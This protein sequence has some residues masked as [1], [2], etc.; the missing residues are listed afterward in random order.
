VHKAETRFAKRDGYGMLFTN[1]TGTGKTFSGLGIVK[2]QERQNKLDQLIIVPDEK[3][4]D[5]WMDSGKPLDLAITR[6]K[7]TKDAGEGIVITTLANLGQND[8][9]ARRKWSHVAVDEAHGLMQS[10]DGDKTLYLQRLHA[11]TGHPDGVRT[12]VDM[13]HREL[14]NELADVRQ[15]ADDAS[16]DLNAVSDDRDRPRLTAALDKLTAQRAKLE[17]RY[18]AALAEVQAEVD[19]MQGEDRTRVTFLSA[20]PFAYEKTVDWANGYLFDYQ[21]DYPYKDVHAYNTPSPHGHFFIRHFGYRMRYGKLTEPDSKVDRGLMQRQF[22]GWLRKQGVL[23]SRMLDVE[24][25]YDR[26]FIAVSNAIGNRIDEALEWLSDSSYGDA[27]IEG[28]SG[29]RD[30]DR[31][32]VR[33]PHAP[34]PAGGDQGQGGRA[35]RQGAPGA[36]PQGRRLPRL[37][38]GRRRQPVQLR[39]RGRGHP[40][41]PGGQAHR[42]GEAAARRPRAGLQLRRA[43]FRAKFADLVGADF[44]RLASPINEFRRSFGADQL[45]MINGLEK[46]TDVLQAY[47][48]FQDDGSG[49]LVALVQADKNKGWSGHD[50]TGK[51]QRVLI[52]LGLPTQPTRSI[53]QEGRIYRTGQHPDSHAIFRYL[54]TGTNWEKWA[55]ATTIAT[56]ASAAEN[57]SMGEQA[58]ALKDSYIAAFDEADTFPPGPRGRGPRRQGA[59]QAQANA[60]L[61]EWDRAKAFYW[62]TQ[63][64]TS[65]TKAQ[66]GKDYFAT[67]EPVGLKMVQWAG[68]R[69][70]DDALEPSAGH[71]AIARWFHEQSNRTAIEPSARLR[72]SLAMVFDGK[73]VEGTFEDHNVVNKYDAIVMNPPFGQGGKTAVDHLAKAATHLREDGRIVALIPTGPAADKKLEKFLY[74]KETRPAKPAFKTPVGDVYPGDTIVLSLIG[75]GEFVMKDPVIYTAM[76]AQYVVPRGEPKSN[77]INVSGVTSIRPG[78]RTEEYSAAAD[79]HL[80]ADIKLPQVTFER[81]GTAVATRVVVLQKGKAGENIQT[82]QRDYS[83]IGDIKELFDRIQDLDLPERPEKPEAAPVADTARPA[84]TPTPTRAPAPARAPTPGQAAAASTAPVP[85]AQLVTVKTASGKELRGVIRPDLSKDQAKAIDPYTWIP[86]GHAGWFIREKYLQGGNTAQEERAVYQVN[87]PQSAYDIDLFPDTLARL[88]ASTVKTAPKRGAK[89]APAP[90]Q[91]LQP[92]VLAV[93]ENLRMPG[94]FHLS[95]QLVQVGVRKLFTDRVTDWPSAA[96]ALAGMS[97]Y[98]M[99]HFDMLVTDADGKP[100]AVVGAFKGALTQTSIYPATLL[101][102]AIRIKGAAKV[103]AVH[104]HPSGTPTLSTADVR[105]STTLAHLFKP[106][107][108]EYQGIAAVAAKD[109]EGGIEWTANDANGFDRSGSFAGG[110]QPTYSVPLVDREIVGNPRAAQPINS[111]NEAKAMALQI[112]GGRSGLM[113]LDAQNALTAWMPLDVT[114]LSSRT[115]AAFERLMASLGDAST[116]AVI[117]V[118]RGLQANVQASERWISGFKNLMSLNDIRVLDAIDPDDRFSM[119]ERGLLEPDD[120]LQQYD[121]AA[122]AAKTQRE[123]AARREEAKP[124]PAPKPTGKAPKVDQADLFNTQQSLFAQRQPGI[125]AYH[126]TSAKAFKNFDTSREGAHFGTSEQATARLEKKRGGGRPKVIAVDLDIKNPLRLPDIGVWNHFNNLHR[127]LSVNGHFTPAEADAVWDAWQRTD[128]AG[129]E[130]LKAT[131]EA[132][133]YDGIVYTNEVE[134]TGDSYIAFR[135]QQIRR[136]PD[137]QFRQTDDQPLTPEQRRNVGELQ[138]HVD[139]ITGTWANAPRVTVVASVASPSVPRAVQR[140]A[141]AAMRAGGGRPQGVY[142]DGEVLLFADEIADP[143]EATKILYHEVLGHHG[144]RGFFGADL[145]KVLSRVANLRG[146][147]I[148]AMMDKTGLDPADPA[149][150][151]R[152]ADE[153][154]AYLAQTRPELGIVQQAIAAIR[155]FLREHVPGFKNLTLTDAD[156]VQ[157]YILPA[158][159]FIERGPGGGG[160][161]GGMAFAKG[162]STAPFYSAL[163]KQLE[164][165]DTKA[166]P[167]AGWSRAP[168]RPGQRRQGEGGG[169]RVVGRARLA[170]HPDGE[171]DQGPAAGL[172]PGQRRARRGSGQGRQHEGVRAKRSPPA[173]RPDRARRRTGLHVRPRRVR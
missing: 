151:L 126:G 23:S 105:L 90:E 3:I 128:D 25:D 118:E 32:R 170:G 158:R 21:A 153:V 34:L 124:A 81:A 27:K 115:G 80:V 18:N 93:R 104:N 15:R 37:Q 125:R 152:A 30:Q 169:G 48:T 135:S 55:F 92:N 9:L 117:V 65:K 16:K 1:G 44:A 112:S 111:P 132:K 39:G 38:Q 120:A 4:G 160:P 22:N 41:R 94:V 116:A 162:A 74:G 110:S 56:R 40:L 64:K 107:G 145:D 123:E 60:A 35:D 167:A 157:A 77:G 96:Q 57:L 137:P 168:H 171:G 33:L 50:T 122:L 69:G 95:S 79:L 91:Q 103:W 147:D 113:A 143:A 24:A 31:Q 131:L 11:I 88:E 2:R 61:T 101:Q 14:V 139:A 133:G 165:I 75:G 17:A 62:G 129:W 43:Q 42:E 63:K 86:K 119:A 149:S 164:A 140:D 156:I 134:G 47:R 70:G 28:M 12:R 109:A 19:A 54:N 82:R 51:H 67:P 26:R 163:R 7:D 148:R 138:Q 10:A 108:L 154:L 114:T 49:P 142:Y 121:A 97:R 127:H 159:G 85:V 84:S 155:N 59:R 78:P 141:V 144:L 98:S 66:E 5:D 106:T 68:M 58:R 83:D 130:A 89:A 173:G 53:Q 20:T 36:G 52:N 72:S 166:A 146:A 13:L 46:R 150:K 102:E 29:V 73:I 6:L 136:A 100:L 71:G 8:E 76:G 87:E 99:E 161:R 45:L 172:H